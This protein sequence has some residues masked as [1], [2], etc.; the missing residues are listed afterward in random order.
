VTECPACTEAG[1]ICEE[2]EAEARAKFTAL[3][4]EAVADVLE[5][6]VGQVPNGPAAVANQALAHARAWKCEE[7]IQRAI[8]EALAMS[9]DAEDL[10]RC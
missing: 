5:G 4:Q 7:R 10:P 1:G 3:V 9:V 2:H 8:D 6:V